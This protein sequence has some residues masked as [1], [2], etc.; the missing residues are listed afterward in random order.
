MTNERIDAYLEFAQAHPHLFVNDESPMALQIILDRDALLGQQEALYQKAD[1]AGQPRNWVDLGI[2]AEDR[3]VVVLRDLVRFPNGGYGGYIRMLNRN[4]TVNQKG[5]DTVIMPI[6]GDRFLLLH[7]FRHEARRW[8]VEFPRGFG[9]VGLTAEENARKELAEET[10]LQA[11]KIEIIG[12][13]SGSVVFFAAWA[14]TDAVSLE[15]DEGI[16][17]HQLVTRAELEAMIRSGEIFDSFTIEAYAYASA[18][19]WWAEK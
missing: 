7:H 13:H 6:V 8:S 17:R 19:A 10:G 12:G 18:Q 3:F 2:V 15:N 14:A 1:A 5:R 16:D 9:E 11:A 4:S